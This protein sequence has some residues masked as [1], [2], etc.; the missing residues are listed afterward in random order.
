[1]HENV[2]V[3]VLF[4]FLKCSLK[5]LIRNRL[6]S[7]GW[8]STVREMCREEL[9]AKGKDADMDQFFRTIVPQVNEVFSAIAKLYV[10]IIF[11]L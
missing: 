3:I 4:V 10:S 2:I 1:L 5:T 9:L 7:S 11:L 8:Q 6:I